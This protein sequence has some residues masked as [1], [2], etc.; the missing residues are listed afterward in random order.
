[1]VQDFHGPGKNGLPRRFAPRNDEG[2][3]LS[4]VIRRGKRRIR[5]CCPRGAK[6]K[7]KNLR[8]KRIRIRIRRSFLF[9]FLFP[10]GTSGGRPLQAAARFTLA[11]HF[12][13]PPGPRQSVLIGSPERGLQAAAA[14]GRGR[15]PAISAAAAFAGRF[16]YLPAKASRG[17]AE[18]VSG[19]VRGLPPPPRLPFTRCTRRLWLWRT[20]RPPWPDPSSH[21]HRIQT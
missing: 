17:K 16:Q 18:A 13:A 15:L 5:F 11:R 10:A 1:M 21:P 6:G 2:R 12:E 8:R 9:S 7:T 19:A 4:V 3:T 20:I 14:G